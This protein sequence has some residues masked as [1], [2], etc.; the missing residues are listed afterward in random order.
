MIIILHLLFVKK[1]S[2]RTSF[3][4]DRVDCDYHM[5]YF[6]DVY[7]GTWRMGWLAMPCQP[8]TADTHCREYEQCEE[9]HTYT[10]EK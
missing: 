1:G 9:L 3:V 7:C 5:L 8:C 6:G 10:V 2:P 4:F